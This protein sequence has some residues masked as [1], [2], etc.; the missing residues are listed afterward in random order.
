VDILCGFP[1]A[2]Q[3]EDATWL[4][5][6]WNCRT[7]D[8]HRDFISECTLYAGNAIDCGILSTKEVVVE[9]MNVPLF[10]PA[11]RFGDRTWQDIYWIAISHPKNN[12]LIRTQGSSTT[13]FYGHKTGLL[14][15]H[16]HP[17]SQSLSQKLDFKMDMLVSKCWWLSFTSIRKIKFIDPMSAEQWSS[18]FLL[19]WCLE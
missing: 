6:A 9:E 7:V 10:W 16:I 1:Q 13:Q 11:L 12:I 5:W 17:F 14:A 4:P 15:W 8:C 3:S 2:T 19:A 18:L